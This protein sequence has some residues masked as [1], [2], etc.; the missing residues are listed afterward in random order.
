MRTVLLIVAVLVGLALASSSLLTVDRAEFVY[1]TQFGQ[2]V[3][4]YDG[5]TDAGLHFKLPWP[6]QSVQRLDHRL[7]VFDLA[8]AELVTL[9]PESQTIDKTLTISA[10][11]CWQIDKDG[12]DRFIKSVGTPERAEA[13]LGQRISSRLGAAIGKMRLDDLISEVSDNHQSA[14]RMDQLSRRLRLDP[15]PDDD[16]PAGRQSL[17]DDARQRYG[18]DLVDIRLR[19]FN[20]PEQVREEIFARIRSERNK[21]VA[22]YQSLGAQKAEE[23]R[24]QAEAESRMI[25][26][27]ARATEQRLKG[28][29]DADA[30]RIRDQAQSKDPAFYTF[31][32]KLAE[33]QRILADNQT[34]LLLSSHRELFDLLFKPPSPESAPAMPKPPARS[35]GH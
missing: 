1:V 33:Y 12:V 17:R 28:Q 32:K 16:S 2:P 24:S 20:Y 18:I 21:K 25:L 29:A 22:D 13:I 14:Q 3:A 35:G 23:I 5:E 30:D 7:H 19:R 4:T 8:G 6:I 34:V 27:D 26:A 15:N 10:Y 31:L 9:D 11:V